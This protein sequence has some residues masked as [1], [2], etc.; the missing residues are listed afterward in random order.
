M[1]LW[2]PFESS[3]VFF[4]CCTNL[5][6]RN[7]ESTAIQTTQATATDATLTCMQ[8]G[9][10]WLCSDAPFWSGS[11]CPFLT[12]KR[13]KKVLFLFPSLL[14]AA[15]LQGE[16]ALGLHGKKADWC[17]LAWEAVSLLLLEHSCGE[18]G[19]VLFFLE[20]RLRSEGFR[21]I[22]ASYKRTKKASRPH[23]TW[24]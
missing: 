16:Q 19:T 9:T 24:P 12:K 6:Q 1:P 17:A 3:P 2:F 10:V 11:R 4:G 20:S 15:G 18:T 21:V 7:E 8:A 14:F 23:G 13:E 22:A 5:D